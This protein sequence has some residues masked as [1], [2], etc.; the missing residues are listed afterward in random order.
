MRGQYYTFEV[1][2]G[3]EGELDE[4]II[5]DDLDT[6]ENADIKFKWA[7]LDES[8]FNKELQINYSQQVCLDNLL[9]RD[10]EY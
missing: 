9:L 8:A 5:I 7:S 1:T 3:K 2:E 10:K 6:K 4:P